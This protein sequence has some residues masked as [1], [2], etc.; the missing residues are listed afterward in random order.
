MAAAHHRK[1]YKTREP[2][3][4]FVAVHFFKGV[5]AMS[6]ISLQRLTRPAPRDLRSAAAQETCGVSTSMVEAMR[7]PYEL[8]ALPYPR[9]ALSPFISE[10]TLRFHYGKHHQ[11]YIDALNK[12][13]D[14]TEFQAM[15]LRAII[16]STAG[17]SG[18]ASIFNNAAQ[19]WNH[20]FYWDSLTPQGG[21]D[22]P[23]ALKR[24]IEASFGSVEACTRE[25]AHAAMTQFETG[26]A[27]LVL[28]DNQI[29]VMKTGGADNPL[30][31]GMTPLLAIDVWEHAYYLD[32]QNR[33]KDYVTGVIDRLI[34]WDFAAKNLA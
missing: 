14:D 1:T 24:M 7:F 10:T 12:A 17:K 22:P 33:R 11:A 20:A 13:I 8:P 34:N 15:P 27:W 19:T 21:G 6:S 25:L 30:T 28:D 32:Y 29:S 31:R 3:S 18:Q 4:S 26:W 23:P 2:G 5:K 9:D 16:Q